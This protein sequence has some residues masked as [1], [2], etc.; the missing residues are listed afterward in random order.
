[1]SLS[2][3]ERDELVSCI[4]AGVAARC[5]DVDHDA[6]PHLADLRDLSQ[7]HRQVPGFGM[8]RI[9]AWWDGWEEAHLSLSATCRLQTLAHDTPAQSALGGW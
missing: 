1:M 6:N 9:E 3:Q 7:G 4:D 2:A 8:L 5:T